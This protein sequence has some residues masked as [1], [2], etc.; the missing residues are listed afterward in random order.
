[1][2]EKVLAYFKSIS[3]KIQMMVT[4]VI[5]AL[6]LVL[7]LGSLPQIRVGY[8]D[9]A[10]QYMLDV[11]NASQKSLE[12]LIEKDADAI[13]NYE[14]MSEYLGDVC[15]SDF[16]TSYAYLVD[17]DGTMLYHPEQSK[18][19]NSVENDVVKG[20]VADIKAG[21]TIAPASVT[22]MYKGAEKFAAY[23]SG[24]GNYILVVTADES[25]V[26]QFLTN[27]RWV[28]IGFAVGMLIL[29]S[30]ICAIL[31]G[32]LLKPLKQAV[33]F[34]EELAAGDLRWNNAY[35]KY[36]KN[37]DEVAHV[38]KAVKRLKLELN[39]VFGDIRLVAG[40]LETNSVSLNENTE[41]AVKNTE[42]IHMAMDEVSQGAMNMAEN[43]QDTAQAMS[44]IG[45]NIDAIAAEADNS[46]QSLGRVNALN[47]EALHAL[48]QL[49]RANAET[50]QAAERVVTGINESNVA[51]KRIDEAVEM[52]LNISGQTNL[53]SLNASIEA[54]R[55]GE[56]GKGFAVVAE[57][58]K[59][60]SEQ[61][62]KSAKTIQDIIADIQIKSQRNIDL[63]DAIKNSVGK[64]ETVLNEVTSKFSDVETS[65]KETVASFN[66]I[67]EQI[68]SLNQGKGVVLDAVEQLSSISEENAAST[69]ETNASAST[70]GELL[71]N[72]S[73]EADKV[74][75]SAMILKDK[76]NMFRL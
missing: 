49:I 17:S 35:D 44:D 42:Q 46:L 15:I 57:E 48:N 72:N 60:L 69:Q 27:L 45:N 18:V 5:V 1:M 29:F 76:L 32:I 52:I 9:L 66:I 67:N 19:G 23:A 65:V 58:I 41:S 24:T 34:I 6:S 31:T 68:E 39:R 3:F 16:T 50:N 61:S 22:Y 53:L 59:S 38:T 25:E 14:T 26:G 4:V 37:D 12:L 2:K 56:A 55:A 21:K 30:I 63:A 20:L 73:E 74:S 13:H 64:E 10:Q 47:D 33:V 62:D 75:G 43:V 51:I 54:A 36:T 70:L 7:L 8:Y 40:E 11:T 28:L 71:A